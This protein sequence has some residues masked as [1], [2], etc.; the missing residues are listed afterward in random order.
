[1]VSLGKEVCTCVCSSADLLGWGLLRL[2]V[3]AEPAGLCPWVYYG[4]DR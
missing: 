1:V 4:E 2:F 3:Y